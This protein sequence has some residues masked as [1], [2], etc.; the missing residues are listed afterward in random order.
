MRK[1]FINV[2]HTRDGSVLAR[3]N[4]E[5][6][7]RLG[8]AMIVFKAMLGGVCIIIGTTRSS[9]AQDD[10]VNQ[11]IV[12]HL[13]ANDYRHRLTP[14]RKHLV[15][16]IGLLNRTGKTIEDDSLD[17][18]ALCIQDRSQNLD[19]KRIWNEVALINIGDCKLSQFCALLDFLAKDITR[20][21]MVNTI[22]LDNLVTLGTFTGT[23]GSENND[24]QHI[25]LP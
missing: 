14:V 22:L 21:D 11:L 1:D 23:W 3:I 7:Q 24:V 18:L 9:A 16:R 12:I 13:K 20:R 10:T 5:L 2:A 17:I 19:H 6:L 25:Q 4:I 8:L 15:K